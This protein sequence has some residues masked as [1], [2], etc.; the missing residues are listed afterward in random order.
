MEDQCQAVH[1]SRTPDPCQGT[2]GQN[3]VGM[4][5]GGGGGRRD[6]HADRGAGPAPPDTQKR[7]QWGQAGRASR[8]QLGT[9][10]PHPTPAPRASS[11]AESQRPQGRPHVAVLPLA[12]LAPHPK[13]PPSVGPQGPSRPPGSALS[14]VLRKRWEPKDAG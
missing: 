14:W 1:S 10:A 12:I 3:L 4:S 8:R 9:P 7:L 11:C 5:Q 13:D 6:S 2:Q